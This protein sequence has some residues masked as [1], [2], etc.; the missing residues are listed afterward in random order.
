[1]VF[2]RVSCPHC[3]NFIPTF[4][5]LADT[6]KDTPRLKFGRVDCPNAG[7][8]CQ[9]QGIQGVPTVKLFYQNASL[10]SAG[11]RD[12]ETLTAW[13]KD[14]ITDDG[15]KLREAA[16]NQPPLAP[17]GDRPGAD[18]L[19]GPRER[20]GLDRPRKFP[21]GPGKFGGPGG[22][23]RPGGPEGFD[24]PDGPRRFGPP[25][26]PGDFRS[27]FP[28]R[29]RNK[30][31]IESQGETPAG[32]PAASTQVQAEGQA[33]PAQV[34]APSVQVQT[35]SAQVQ[36]PSTQVQAP[37]SQVQTTPAQIQAP[38]AQVQSPPAQ[39]QT[40]PAQAQAPPTPVQT[41]PA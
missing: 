38:P 39:V 20:P 40:P 13:L 24:G 8:V 34:Q 6:L 35:P 37:P 41:P 14:F 21:R 25:G 5:T 26:S 33:P 7:H 23:G 29:R 17:R 3:K 1:M 19:H 31:Q 30:T 12:V 10:D 16:K 32:T 9:G 36:T 4:N 28:H 15:T 2:Y 18:G 27:R 11:S 22:F